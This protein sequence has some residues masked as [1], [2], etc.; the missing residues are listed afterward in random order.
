[1]KPAGVHGILVIDKPAGITSRD[2]VNRVA[3]W[4]P[5]GTRLGHAGT[6]DPLA[7]G[8]LVVCAGNATRLIEYIQD[9]DKIYQ[10]ELLLGARSDTDDA[11]GQ[12]EAVP[13]SQPPE[14]AAV[15]ACLNGFVGEI[16]QAPPRYSAARVSGR[17]AYDLARAGREFSLKPRGVVIHDI[18]LLT[19]DYPNL[20]LEIRC[21]KGTYI[22]SLARDVGERLGCG[23]LVRTLRRT[24]IGQLRL[25]EALSLDAPGARERCRLLPLAAAVGQLPRIILDGDL[26]KRLRQG[27]KLPASQVEL[28]PDEQGELAV[29]DR[30]GELVAIAA[31]QNGRLCPTKVL[32]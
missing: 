17:R 6:L 9:M 10:A 24:A 5:P 31:V 19:Y 22:R 15:T 4:L 32:V 18:Q 26:L 25:A 27:Q 30:Q 13:V 23:A 8:V 29:T 7:T 21:S 20:A 16:E 11:D 2:V 28:A 1:M 14:L 3:K 12:V